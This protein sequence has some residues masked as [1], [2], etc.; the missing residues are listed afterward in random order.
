T[1]ISAGGALPVP[2][3]VA[4]TVVVHVAGAVVAPGVYEL[5]GGSRVQ[6]AIA[7]AG[8]ATPD[9]DPDALNLAAAVV[10]GLRVYVPRRG[11][12]VPPSPPSPS[13][14]IA[15]GPVDLNSASAEQLDQLPGVGPALAAAIVRHRELH[16]PFA[17]IDALLD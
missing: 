11:E 2:P 8:G 14:L 12:A 10:D 17:G 6:A 1:T 3:S 7:S 9:G 16:G 5:P 15:A 13:S 4:E